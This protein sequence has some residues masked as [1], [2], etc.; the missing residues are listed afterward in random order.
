MQA[1]Q[2]CLTK[3]GEVS[4]TLPSQE[5][6]RGGRVHTGPPIALALENDYVYVRLYLFWDLQNLL[7]IFTQAGRRPAPTKG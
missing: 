4:P 7:Y 6:R 5:P 2:L 3:M 1:K